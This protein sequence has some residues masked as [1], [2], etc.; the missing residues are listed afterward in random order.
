MPSSRHRAAMDWRGH[1]RRQGCL[2]PSTSPRA[3]EA[4]IPAPQGQ[5]PLKKGGLPARFETEGTYVMLHR[6]VPARMV[7]RGALLVVM[8][9]LAMMHG[10][11][12]SVWITGAL[13]GTRES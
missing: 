13:P 7:V 11:I 1:R 10:V 5:A 8:V 2:A 9:P 4:S 3:L 12:A 6:S